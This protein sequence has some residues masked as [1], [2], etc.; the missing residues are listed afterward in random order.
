MNI[1]SLSVQLILIVKVYHL[2][3]RFCHCYIPTWR[4]HTDP[5][6]KISRTMT[7]PVPFFHGCGSPQGGY[8]QGLYIGLYFHHLHI[9]FS[10]NNMHTSNFVSAFANNILLQNN[11][12]NHWCINWALSV[13]N[14]CFKGW[15]LF[16]D[17][18]HG[19][20]RCKESVMATCPLTTLT[21]PYWCFITNSLMRERDFGIVKED[22]TSWQWNISILDNMY[23]VHIHCMLPARK[24]CETAYNYFKQ[25][26]ATLSH[27]SAMLYVSFIE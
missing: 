18:A 9:Y 12:A 17:P 11:M 8:C 16:T 10:K 24:V 25:L 14:S 2:L 6:Q 21:H 1:L 3:H 20:Q 13:L 23:T 5:S 15:S 4:T 7:S 22:G 26:Y 19:Q 27:D